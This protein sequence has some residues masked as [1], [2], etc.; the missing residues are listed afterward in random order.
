VLI[1][2]CVFTGIDFESA[3]AERGQTDVPVQIGIA[4]WS[5]EK[6]FHDPYV[7]YLYTEQSITWGA[8]RVHGITTE[9]LRDA[10]SFLSLWP[11]LKER[12]GSSILTAHACGTEKRFLRTFPG[13]SFGP[14]IDTLHISRAAFPTEKK[15]KLEN[16]S[17]YAGITAELD[18]YITDRTWHDALYDATASVLLVADYITRHNLADHPLEYLTHPDLSAYHRVRKAP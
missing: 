11:L 2:D 15:H 17:T 13:H 12:L 9:D 7:S 18:T 14:W 8:Q 10:P 16:A 5:V 4:S 3:G 1:K 6:G